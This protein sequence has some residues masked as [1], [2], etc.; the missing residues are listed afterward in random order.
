MQCGRAS[1]KSVRARKCC[2]REH[3][4]YYQP[5]CA[6]A[7]AHADAA[8]LHL[9]I[10]GAVVLVS[11]RTRAHTHPFLIALS[12]YRF[13]PLRLAF[14]TFHL[15]VS[16]LAGIRRMP[17]LAAVQGFQCNL[18]APRRQTRTVQCTGV[19]CGAAF[20]LRTGL[21]YTWHRSAVR[22]L[23]GYNR[24][25]VL[26][27]WVRIARKSATPMCICTDVHVCMHVRMCLCS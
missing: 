27:R 21:H 24:S 1:C 25:H 8:K 3:I 17:A 6:R 9:Q 23:A 16:W 10:A 20:Y 7:G 15:Q 14:T 19:V 5:P 22:R 13:P 4:L 2:K 18:H 12:Y 26:H 11:A